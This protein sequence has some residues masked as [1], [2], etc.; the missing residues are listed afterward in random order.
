M[1]AMLLENASSVVKSVKVKIFNSLHKR[2]RILEKYL[3][4]AQNVFHLKKALILDMDPAYSLECSIEISER[5]NYVYYYLRVFAGVV[6]VQE[7]RRRLTDTHCRRT[8]EEIDFIN[9]L[10]EMGN[11]KNEGGKITSN[12]EHFCFIIWPQKKTAFMMT[13]N[14]Q[15]LVMAHQKT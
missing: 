4:C 14:V 7:D 12:L 10:E 13:G 8:G 6:W 11:F 1:P 15:S 3:S 2:R 9:R 5:K